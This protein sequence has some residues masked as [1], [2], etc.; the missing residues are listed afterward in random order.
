MK[1][2]QPLSFFLAQSQAKTFSALELQS[3]F[4]GGNF[5]EHWGVNSADGVRTDSGND[6]WKTCRKPEMPKFGFTSCSGGQCRTICKPGYFTIG[7]SN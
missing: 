5:T 4:F 2:F 3:S 7:E 6:E 1:V